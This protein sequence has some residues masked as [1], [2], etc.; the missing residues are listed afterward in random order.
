MR[1]KSPTPSRPRS[2]RGRA[3]AP[4][5][6]PQEADRKLIGLAILVIVAAMGLV[7]YLV[8]PDAARNQSYQV[9]ALC[10]LA[11]AAAGRALAGYREPGAEPRSPRWAERLWLPAIFLAAV[12]PYLPSLG[13]GFLSDDY[14]LMAAMEKLKGPVEALTRTP[15]PM[16]FRPLHVLAWWGQY[17]LWGAAPAGYHAVSVLFHA[18]NAVLVA[19]L[20]RRLT[21]SHAA[22]LTGGLLFALHPL[23]PETVAWASCQLDLQATLLSLLSLACLDVYL[24]SD[25]PGARSVA[26]VG[27]GVAFFLA[28]ATKESPLALPGVAV[29]W[30]AL[31]S[32]R[33]R[34][35]PVLWVG[36]S[37]AAVLAAYLALRF[38]ALGAMGGYYSPTGFWSAFVISVPLRQTALFFFPLHRALLGIASW[39]LPLLILGMAAFLCWCARD[40][41]A[42]P[43]RRLVLYLGFVFL[44]S[45]P[46]WRLPPPSADLEYT[47][48]LYLPTL[49]LVWLIGD[50]CA[51]RGL[52]WRRAGGVTVAALVLAGAL[53]VWYLTPWLGARRVADET[54]AAGVRMVEETPAS[55]AEPTFFVQSLPET[56]NGAQVFRNSFPVA[57]NEEL[58]RKALV[59]TVGVRG[60]LP[61]ETMLLAPLQPGE[62]LYEWDAKRKR[63]NLLRQGGRPR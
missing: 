36:G 40:L 59:Q 29:L 32:E 60:D 43:A 31:R 48:F 56:Y 46:V 12:L 45:V 33:F 23:H 10:L 28:V 49:G 57:L 6:R 14:G 7:Q 27:A 19:V 44:A 26:L 61:P 30:A 9:M 4:S 51:A 62:F 53:C 16:V 58:G 21:G 54:L 35:R 5:G 13:V 18:V 38:S 42:V 17:H 1:A 37:Y 34:W 8:R 39:L 25:R 15:F 11:A 63:M 50:L 20:G 47:R 22:G 55:V 41:S 3:A 24:I 2:K 52:A